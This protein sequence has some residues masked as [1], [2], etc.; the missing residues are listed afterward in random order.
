MFTKRSLF[1]LIP[2]FLFSVLIFY[3]CSGNK[4]TIGVITNL[5]G[6][7]AQSS[8]DAFKSVK[9]AYLESRDKYKNF[10]LEILPIDNSDNP[11]LTGKAYDTIIGKSDA[12]I[13]ITTS[14][15]F[16][17]AYEPIQ[18]HRDVLHMLIGSTTTVV[19]GQDDNIIRNTIDMSLEQARIAEFLNQKNSG[20]L[21]VL[22]ETGKNDSYT[23]QAFEY[24]GR[25]YSGDIDPVEFSAVDLNFDSAL[26]QLEK[27]DYAY[28]YILAGGTPREAGILIQKIHEYNPDIYTVTTPWVKGEFFIQALGSF[29]ERVIVP[30]HI[31]T[32]DENYRNFAANFFEKNHSQPAYQ[33][34]LAY[35]ASKILFE[36]IWETES[37]DAEDLKEYILSRQYTGTTGTL[38][39]DSFGDLKGEL[40]FYRISG[41][42]YELIR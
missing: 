16:L 17:A 36:A 40:Y 22:L 32:D 4:Y 28:V 42:G 6:S 3:S 11:E 35:D 18:K 8:N 15:A 39:F 30:A 5:E 2:F 25:N 34:P 33:A 38:E 9:M 31:S 23:K 7:N 10:D 20:P 27:K 19:S 37:S 24:F 1:L 29:S 13:I 12:I 14:T 41:K 21:L 26:N